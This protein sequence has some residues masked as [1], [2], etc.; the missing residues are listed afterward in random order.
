MHGGCACNIG[1][2]CPGVEVNALLLASLCLLLS[3]ASLPPCSAADS[4]GNIHG[5]GLGEEAVS[6]L[7]LCSPRGWAGSSRERGRTVGSLECSWG[8]GVSWMGSVPLLI[9]CLNTTGSPAC[10]DITLGT[11]RGSPGWGFRDQIPCF[12]PISSSW[13]LQSWLRKRRPELCGVLGIK[14]GHSMLSLGQAPSC[15]GNRD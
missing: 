1:L 13:K 9:S 2:A 5:C 8:A 4:A 7:L 3:G 12:Q 14:T 10:P 6:R 11:P 15:P